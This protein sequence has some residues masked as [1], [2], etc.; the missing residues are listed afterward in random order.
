M[1]RVTVFYLVI[2][3]ISLHKYYG[4][5]HPN[6]EISP[7]KQFL[8]SEVGLLQCSTKMSATESTIIKI[9]FEGKQ[10]FAE[11]GRIVP[12]NTFWTPKQSTLGARKQTLGV[13]FFFTINIFI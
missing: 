10:L 11:M 3:C 5:D 2:T 4:S 7:P 9:R 12:Q 1:N 8:S 13:F 6:K